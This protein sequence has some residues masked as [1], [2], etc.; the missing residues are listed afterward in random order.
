MQ[1]PAVINAVAS[2]AGLLLLLVIVSLAVW[3]FA[4]GENFWSMAIAGNLFVI[5]VVAAAWS[6]ALFRQRGA[7]AGEPKT[8]V[9]WIALF[10]LCLGISAVF[11]V[12]DLAVAH[13]GISLVFTIGAVA[14]TLVALPGA[15]RAWFLEVLKTSRA[16]EETDVQHFH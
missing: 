8:W 3:L 12:I 1:R 6:G 15:L 14:M 13:P 5:P 11:V 16:R 7:A 10:A 9:D 2:A 4:P